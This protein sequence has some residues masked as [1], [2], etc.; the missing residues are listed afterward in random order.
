MNPEISIKFRSLR[1]FN[2]TT[3]TGRW[4]SFSHDRESEGVIMVT[5]SADI[6]ASILEFVVGSLS[7]DCRD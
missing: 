3:L 1:Q 4:K 2:T 6:S 7:R 5:N